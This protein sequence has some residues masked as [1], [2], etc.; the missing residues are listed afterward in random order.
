MTDFFNYVKILAIVLISS[1]AV[2]LIWAAF[3]EKSSFSFTGKKHVMSADRFT[4]GGK[5]C[6]FSEIE[7][8]ENKAVQYLILCD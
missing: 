6:I 3:Q 5:S 7:N 8:T 4:M 1:F 2:N